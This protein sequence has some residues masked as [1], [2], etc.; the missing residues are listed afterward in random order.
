[1]Y[2]SIHH[3]PV[4]GVT[5]WKQIEWDNKSQVPKLPLS[6]LHDDDNDAV[7]EGIQSS[8]PNQKRELSYHIAR[9]LENEF[10]S[11]LTN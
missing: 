1:M 11:T 7:V 2:H 5:K 6:K 9:S 3:Q 4:L 10:N 8:C